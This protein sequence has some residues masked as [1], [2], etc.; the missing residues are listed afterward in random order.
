VPSIHCT[1]EV[2]CDIAT[3]SLYYIR[4]SDCHL[5][6]H[7]KYVREICAL[8]G[9]YAA[10]NNTSVPTFR[11]NPSVTPNWD[12]MCYFKTNSDKKHTAW[13]TK[14]LKILAFLVWGVY[15]DNA[16]RNILSLKWTAK[17][18]LP[19]CLDLKHLTS[20]GKG[21]RGESIKPVTAS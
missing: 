10:S 9:F 16:K 15:Y 17:Q 3:S 6:H 21:S 18:A 13:R 2:T 8:V 12:V 1:S 5:K 4:V 11:D 7:N 20:F 19:R 14:Y